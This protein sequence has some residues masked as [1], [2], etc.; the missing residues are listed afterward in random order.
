MPNPDRYRRIAYDKRRVPNVHGLRPYRVYV[1]IESWSGPDHTGTLSQQQ[2][3]ITE[4]G[5][6]PPKVRWVTDEER[7]LGGYDSGTL[8]VGPIT[9]AFSHN[10]VSGGTALSVLQPELAKGEVLAYLLVGPGY[11]AQGGRFALK[12][13]K[14]DRAPRYMLTLER[15]S[16]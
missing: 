2:T 4:S 1:L 3:E 15:V 12:D 14:T 7:A 16:D 10:G 8:R 9:P 11:P 5:G 6:A 13:I